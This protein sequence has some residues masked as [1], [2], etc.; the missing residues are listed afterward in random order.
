MEIDKKFEEEAAA[1]VAAIALYGPM[2]KVKE[3]SESEEEGD[4]KKHK[5]KVE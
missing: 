1:K 2:T 5:V 3:E 4:D